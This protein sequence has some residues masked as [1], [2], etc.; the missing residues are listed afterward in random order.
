VLDISEMAHV[1]G[2]PKCEPERFVTDPEF[3][4]ILPNASYLMPKANL[5]APMAQYVGMYPF[6]SLPHY[7]SLNAGKWLFLFQVQVLSCFPAIP[8]P[9]KPWIV[10]GIP[11]VRPKRC[12]RADS[13]HSH[14]SFFHLQK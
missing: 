2:Y 6:H 13:V 12:R 3:G 10:P 4:T 8:N 7:E 11:M 1:L 9:K 5:T 14:G